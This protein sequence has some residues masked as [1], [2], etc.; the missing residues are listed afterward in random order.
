LPEETAQVQG[1]VRSRVEFAG[2]VDND[3]ASSRLVRWQAPLRSLEPPGIGER[4]LHLP[5]LK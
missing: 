2:N 3:P 5:G 4:T 1:L